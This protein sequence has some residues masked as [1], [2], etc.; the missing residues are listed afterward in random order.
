LRVFFDVDGVLIDGWHADTARRRP[1]NARLAEDLDMDAACFETLLF[2]RDAGQ[3]QSVIQECATG[4]RDLLEALKDILPQTGYDGSV[5]DFVAYWFEKD[6]AINAELFEIIASL[7]TH[8]EVEVYV[9]TGQEHYR[10][11]YLW[12]TLGFAN[13]FDGIFYSAAVGHS[14]KDPRFFEAINTALSIGPDEKPLLV[15]DQPEVI[16]V[17]RRA[18]WEGIVFE[19][20]ADMHRHPRIAAILD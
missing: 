12:N 20:A 17:A 4:T 1:W 2:G 9:A 8:D 10:A 15:D 7:R 5:A 11:D 16:D 14:K 3:R 13:R 6:S 18:G 19:S